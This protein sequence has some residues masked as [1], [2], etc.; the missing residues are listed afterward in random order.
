MDRVH[1]LLQANVCVNI[2]GQLDIG[3]P[4]QDL[5]RL[6]RNTRFAE[7][8]DERMPQAVEVG[9][10][11]RFVFVHQEVAGC[12]KPFFMLVVHFVDPEPPSGGEIELHHVRRLAVDAASLFRDRKQNFR[13]RFGLALFEP[14]DEPFDDIRVQKLR[15]LAPVLRIQ[16]F[17]GHG[18]C[19]RFQIETAQGQAAQFA[20]SKTRP[21][22]QEI[23][24]QVSATAGQFFDFGVAG[25]SVT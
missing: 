20:S 8:T 21:C 25:V 10:Q 13:I 22:S 24:G 16:G 17:D 18:R 19:R 5:G 23:T 11:T 4:S 14:L 12:P 2:H 6:H 15:V 7:I 9:E 3:M 1:L